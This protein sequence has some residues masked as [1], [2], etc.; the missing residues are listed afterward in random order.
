MPNLFESAGVGGLTLRN[1]LVRSAT[2]ER[3][4][5]TSTGA[6]LPELAALYARL[7]QGGIGLI[8]TGHTYVHPRGKV[9]AWM[10]SMADGEMIPAWRQTIQPA[11]DAGARVMMQINHAGASADPAVT[12]HPLSP[13]GVPIRDDAVPGIMEDADI[14]QAIDT[15]GEA[16]ARVREA[17]FDG[18]QLH[19]AHGYCACQFLTPRTNLRTDCW[20]GDPQRRR[21]FLL[22]MIRAARSRVGDDFPLWVKLGVA[23]DRASGLR[24]A[25]GARIAAACVQA[26]VD[27]IEI[28]HGLGIPLEVDRHHEA[29]YR[30]LAGAVRAAVG[31][32][33]PLALVSG[34][35]SVPGMEAVVQDGLVQL[36]SLSR[37][38]IAEP[39]LPHRLQADPEYVAACDRCNR[40]RPTPPETTVA[41]R[42]PA[43]LSR[44]G[45]T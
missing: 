26:G 2:A 15:F 17:G 34:F 29:H 9:N 28:S 6:P 22:G 43:V 3:L 5:D 8:I 20:G 33:Y 35:R 41:C 42:N 1:R 21:A 19:A 39:E 13:S 40:C 12:P 23:G 10:A 27:C 37:P 38:L 32:E 31:P 4:A 24:P 45:E 16:A 44:L 14:R 18:V 36:I 30:P 25:D 11:R 7:A